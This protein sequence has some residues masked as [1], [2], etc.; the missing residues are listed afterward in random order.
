[1]PVPAQVV[2]IGVGS[3]GGLAS[4]SPWAYKLTIT[5][6]VMN[7]QLAAAS[8][9]VKVFQRVGVGGGVRK[10]SLLLRCAEVCGGCLGV[11]ASQGQ[12]ACPWDRLHADTHLSARDCRLNSPPLPRSSVSR[13]P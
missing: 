1:V 3:V 7:Y 6:G 10:R 13:S 2:Y 12:G 11:V 5:T 9:E 4:S 8:W